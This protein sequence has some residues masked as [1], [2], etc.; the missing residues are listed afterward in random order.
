MS[1]FCNSIHGYIIIILKTW[2]HSSQAVQYRCTVVKPKQE[3][4]GKP[5]IRPL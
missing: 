3:S 5:K 1:N 4:I 2:C